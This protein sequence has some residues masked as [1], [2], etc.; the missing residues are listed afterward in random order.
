MVLVVAD[1][2]DK[3]A[4]LDWTDSGN[5]HES[6]PKVTFRHLPNQILVDIFDLLIK[7]LEILVACLSPVAV[8][9]LTYT[10]QRRK[11]LL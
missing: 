4:S 8:Q 6:L 11:Y 7:V 9:R 2:G 1:F 3:K 5:C 10:V